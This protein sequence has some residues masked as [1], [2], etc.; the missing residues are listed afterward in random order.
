MTATPRSTESIAVGAPLKLACELGSTK[1]TLGF[2]TAPARAPTG[3]DDRRRGSGGAAAG[4][5]DRQGAVRAASRRG[6]AELLSTSGRISTPSRLAWRRGR[7]PATNT[8]RPAPIGG[9]RSHG[10][11]VG[12]VR[13]P[14]PAPRCSA[15]SCWARGPSAMAGHSARGSDE[16]RSPL[17]VTRPCGTRASATPAAPSSDG[18]GSR[19]RGAGSAGNRTVR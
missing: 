11:S 12:C 9:P 16:C 6:G 3:A 18:G 2:T 14:R 13:S 10:S 4:A 19:S 7:P 5:A 15:R 1:G 8:S 17:A